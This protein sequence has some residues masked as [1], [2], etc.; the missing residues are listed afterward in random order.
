[1]NS[2][3]PP[4]SIA[5][6]QTIP[7]VADV[8]QSLQSGQI[9]ANQQL[10]QMNELISILNET[11][12]RNQLQ[13]QKS[14]SLTRRNIGA[15]MLAAGNSIVS[16]ES[17]SSNAPNVPDPLQHFAAIVADESPLHL[18]DAECSILME[19]IEPSLTLRNWIGK[20]KTSR[21]IC[22]K[23]SLRALCDKLKPSVCAVKRNL[24]CLF[25]YFIIKKC[26]KIRFAR[27]DSI[28]YSQSNKIMT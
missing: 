8:L 11:V 12:I 28:I 10:I 6:M 14:V 19:R 3:P 15:A 17:P 20:F 21:Q 25:T 9:I 13:L 27:D 5:L 4:E 18:N 26:N 2:T 22:S 16:Q 23:L 7:L 1:M 24:L